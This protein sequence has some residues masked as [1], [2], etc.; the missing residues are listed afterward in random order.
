MSAFLKRL[1]RYN[2]F[3]RKT[4]TKENSIKPATPPLRSIMFKIVKLFYK[5][6]IQG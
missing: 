2:F 5:H 3:L 6:N 4:T 1:Q